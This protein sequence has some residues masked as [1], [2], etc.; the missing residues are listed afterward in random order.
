MKKLGYELTSVQ[1][2]V[3]VDGH[4]RA[5][6]VKY[7]EAFLAKVAK[8][9]HLCNEYDDITLEVIEPT[10]L[11]GERKHVPVHHD[12]SIFRSNELQQRV[13][14]KEGKM[15]LRKKGQG[16]AIHVSDFITEETGRL[17]LSQA[18]VGSTLTIVVL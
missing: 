5:D 8:N 11:P 12:E 10:L 17:S 13:W 9:E 4:E 1:K 6:V 2:G 3:Y 16:K 15:P 18:Q 7:R 14:T